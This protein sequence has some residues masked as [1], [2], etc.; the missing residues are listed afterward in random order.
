MTTSPYGDA[1]LV[2]PLYNEAE[3]VGDVVRA[4]RIVFPHIVCV[5]DGS[6]DDSGARAREAGAVVVDHPINLGQG[7]ALQTGLTYA[8][9]Q[10]ACRYV[11]TFDSDGQHQVSDAAAM[12]DVLRADEVDVVFGSRFLDGRTQ[13]GPP[14]LVST[15]KL[16]QAGFT[17]VMDTEV[18]FRKAFAEMQSKK[19]LPPR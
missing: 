15:V 16:M 14:A 8:V 12:V 4:A 10:P 18:M 5:N 17:E 3:V 11:V 7:A 19:L 6:T 1:W 2:V 9:G 13:P